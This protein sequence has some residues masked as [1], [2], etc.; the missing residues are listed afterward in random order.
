MMPEAMTTIRARLVRALD[1]HSLINP[2]FAWRPRPRASGSHTETGRSGLDVIG[3]RWTVSFSGQILTRYELVKR[4]VMPFG[5]VVNPF[6]IGNAEQIASYAG[7]HFGGLHRSAATNRCHALRLLGV[8]VKNDGRGYQHAAKS[9]YASHRVFSNLHSMRRKRN[10]QVT[11]VQELQVWT[12]AGRGYA[13]LLCLTVY[14][15]SI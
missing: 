6:S 8:Q 5:R 10:L 9:E 1:L 11:R 4:A 15:S 7:H 3:E 12:G 2:H 14:I 13:V